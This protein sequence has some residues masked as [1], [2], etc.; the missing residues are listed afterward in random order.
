MSKGVASQALWDKPPGTVSLLYFDDQKLQ[1]DEQNH[2]GGCEYIS[3][4]V[5]EIIRIHLQVKREEA[6][7]GGQGGAEVHRR[8]FAAP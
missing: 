8:A 5:Q 6:L 7:H 2:T 3:L 1:C 4:L